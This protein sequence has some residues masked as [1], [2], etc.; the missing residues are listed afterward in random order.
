MSDEWI[1]LLHKCDRQAY[2]YLFY[3]SN[4]HNFRKD[5]DYGY[6]NFREIN[7]YFRTCF[8]EILQM[9][10]ISKEEI[11]RMTTTMYTRFQVE[12]R[13][14][15]VKSRWKALLVSVAIQKQVEQK[16]QSNPS[17]FQQKKEQ[18]KSLIDNQPRI[19]PE[20]DPYP[21]LEWNN[22]SVSKQNSM[23]RFFICLEEAAFW[24]RDNYKWE[25]VALLTAAMACGENMIYSCGG[26]EKIET[27][28]RRHLLFIMEETM[29]TSLNNGRK[30]VCPLN[31]YR[32]K[33]SRIANEEEGEGGK[34]AD[35]D[36]EDSSSSSTTVAQESE[37]EDEEE[38]LVIMISEEEQMKMDFLDHEIELYLSNKPTVFDFDV[39]SLT[40]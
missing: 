19:G 1:N 8:Q 37:K 35:D 33:R 12:T 26:G 27:S 36:Q 17:F 18:L 16:L 9:E 13:N 40:S 10:T 25:R 5:A 30:F 2:K 23:C 15:H 24:C 39:L 7:E 29:F 4:N 22:E 38:H 3:V 32:R 21:L 28:Y 11:I 6:C 14:Y 31:M 20:D 34:E